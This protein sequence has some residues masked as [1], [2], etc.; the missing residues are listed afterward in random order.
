[1]E[2]SEEMLSNQKTIINNQEELLKNQATIIT[3]QESLLANQ[4]SITSNQEVIV[5]NQASIISNQ[6]Q[7]VDNQIAL[8]VIS[9]TQAYLLNLLKKIAGQEESHEKT[10]QFLENLKIET[11]ASVKAKDLAGPE[12]L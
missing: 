5:H 3:N 4:E 6:K 12:D 7:I 9:Q 8:S 10:V 11:E 1:M 2:N